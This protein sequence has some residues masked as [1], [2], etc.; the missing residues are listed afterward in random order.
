V[1]LSLVRRRRRM[2]YKLYGTHKSAEGCGLRQVS[3]SCFSPPRHCPVRVQHARTYARTHA[4]LYARTHACTHA[5]TH[6]RT[7]GCSHARSHACVMLSCFSTRSRPRIHSPTHS[8]TSSTGTRSIVH[9][10]TLYLH[11]HPTLPVY[12]PRTLQL[13]ATLSRMLSRCPPTSHRVTTCSGGGGT[14][15][16][17]RRSGPLALTS[18][19]S[20]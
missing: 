9:P 12:W 10:L 15:R 1:W 2:P 13:A 18:R 8:P 19:S 17:L 11:A 5:R 14:A 16:R 7:H 3:A 20:E 6:A 4:Q